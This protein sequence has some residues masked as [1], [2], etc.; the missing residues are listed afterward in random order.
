[1]K[2]V[3]LMTVLFCTA[4]LLSVAADAQTGAP[5]KIGFINS[6]AFGDEKAGIT[7]YNTAVN[8]VNTEFLPVQKELQT[9][10]AKLEA[11]AKEVED[12]R[13]LS[14]ADPKA[15]GAKI[16]EAEKLQRDIKFKSEDAKVRFE[17]RQQAVLGPV[18]EAIGKSLQNYA[19]QRG[20]T[21]IFDV[22]KD[23]KGLL[24]AVGDE[25]ADVTRDFIVFFNALP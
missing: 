22:S 20:F 19:K 14:V 7:K 15:I 9:M 24:L 3:R 18:M 13:R 2:T 21:V 10:N 23:D 25:K 16:D 11:L 17:K 4:A 5:S 1:M 6:Y 12:L 8:A